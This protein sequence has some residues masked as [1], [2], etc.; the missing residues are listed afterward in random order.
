M[1]DEQLEQPKTGAEHLRPWQFKPGQSG[2]PK[3]RPKGP[4]LKE[5]S[6]SYLES[7]TDEERMQFMTGIDKKTIWEMAEGKPES[8]T[9]LTG[10]DGEAIKVEAQITGMK[11][12]Q[13]AS[14]V[15]DKES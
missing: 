12:I 14:G 11:I 2:N 9:E 5:W 10:K 8:K 4:S 15:Q 7:L 3:G 13:D 6:R 1:D